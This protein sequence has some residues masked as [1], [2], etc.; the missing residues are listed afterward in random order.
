V[1][2]VK[3][4]GAKIAVWST[5]NTLSKANAVAEKVSATVVYA[6]TLKPF[7]RQ[8]LKSQ[9]DRGMLIASI[10]NGAV[11]G[12]FGESIG[13][14]LRFGWPDAFIPHGSVEDLE[15]A[16]G[17]DVESIASAIENCKR[18]LAQREACGAG[19]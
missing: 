3:R 1:N 10:E 14:D 9:R 12:G 13:A 6:D 19:L 16:F 17:L 15:R 7:D 4:D 5:G 11:T 18:R 8:L 2:A